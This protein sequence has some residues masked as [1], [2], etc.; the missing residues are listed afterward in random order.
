[1]PEGPEKV[2]AASELLSS[3]FRT[4]VGLFREGGNGMRALMDEVATANPGLMEAH[5]AALKV[6]EKLWNE[7]TLT[8]KRLAGEGFAGL[9]PFIKSTITDI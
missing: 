9:A 3:R 8:L 6:D 5:A 4:L 2:A 1:M 7:S